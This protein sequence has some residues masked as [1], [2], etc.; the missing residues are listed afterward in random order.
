MPQ[1]GRSSAGDAKISREKKEDRKK[2]A[3]PKVP[4]QRDRPSPPK[5][6]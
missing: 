2:D 6:R 5:P 1:D 4:D 3:K